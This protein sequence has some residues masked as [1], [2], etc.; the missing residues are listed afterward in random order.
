M[1]LNSDERFTALRS[2]AEECIYEDELHRLLEKNPDPVCY[3]WFEPSPMMD[4]EQVFKQKLIPTPSLND[5]KLISTNDDTIL[6]L[7]SFRCLSYTAY[8]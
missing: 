5:F 2:I 4:I 3:V 7:V 8:L 6:L 1:K